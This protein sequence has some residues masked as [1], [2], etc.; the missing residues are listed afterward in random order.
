MDRRIGKDYSLFIII[1]MALLLW[2]CGGVGQEKPEYWPTHGWRTATPESQGMDSALLLDM[3]DVIWQNDIKIDSVLVIRNRYIVLDAYSFPRDAADRHNIYSCSKS[4]TSALIGIAIDK[5]FIKSVHAPV[6]DFFPNHTAKN[7]D[8]DKKAMTL[9]HVLTMT[10]GL[11]CRD[12][13]RYKWVGLQQLRDSVD[14]V[15][16]MIDLPMAQEPG[17][18]FEYCNGATFLLSAILQQKTGMDALSFA[19][20]HLFEPLGISGVSWPSNPHGITVGYGRIYMRPRDM[21]KFGY[22]YLNSGVWEDKQIISSR[23]IKESTRKHADTKGFMDYGYQWWTMGSGA[24]TALGYH[25]QFIFV[26]PHKNIVAVFTS[27]LAQKDIFTPSVLL[28]SNIL[29]SVMSDKPLPENLEQEKALQD[30]VALWQETSPTDRAKV[31]E[32]SS[33]AL[34]GL[35]PGLYVNNEYGFSV[36]YD[37]KLTVTDHEKEPGQIFRIKAPEGVPI[38]T[39]GVADIPQGLALKDTGQFLLKLYQKESQIKDAAIRKQELITLSDG[40]QANYGEI[41]WRY[42]SFDLVTVA[43]GAYKDDKLIGVSVVGSRNMPTEYLAEMVKSLKFK[44]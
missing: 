18:H 44:N 25:G 12:S 41:T 34:T 24:Y 22:L 27:N 3:L 14:W 21:A 17:T 39:V 35:R 28:R 2:S 9:E 30:L 7:L 6:L 37:P 40:T 42:R 19:E 8:A 36:Q 33:K 11:E 1:L 4:V 29:P 32:T 43:V 31:R 26:V 23:W 38:F 5:G 16:F 10:T 15:Q 20:E 13:Y